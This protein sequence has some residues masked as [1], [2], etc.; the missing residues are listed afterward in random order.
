MD[1][2]RKPAD[3]EPDATDYEAAGQE[4]GSDEPLGMDERVSF[5]GVKPEEIMRRLLRTPPPERTDESGND[6]AQ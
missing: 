4:P 1:R 3:A 5:Y 2:E 6:E